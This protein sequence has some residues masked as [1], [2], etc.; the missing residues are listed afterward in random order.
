M[1]NFYQSPPEISTSSQSY[2]LTKKAK[3]GWSLDRRD[4]KTIEAFMPLWEW[5]YQYYF[6]VQTSGWEHVSPNEKVLL[7]G[8]HN[9]GLAAPDM[10]LMMYDWFKRFGTE[11]PIY[12][13]MHPS[14]WQ[15]N[16]QIAELAA[17]VGAIVA[18]PKMGYKAL[19]SGAS[20]LVYPGGAKDVFRPYSLRDRIY[21]GNNQAFIKLALR[22][23]VPIVPVISHGA[24]DTFIVLADIYD[25][26]KQ[27]HDWGMPWFMGIDPET[28]PIYLGLPWGVAFGPLPNIPFPVTI[29][30]RVCP[31]IV[32]ESYGREAA[33]DREYVNACYN[34]V[35]SQMQRELD[36]LVRS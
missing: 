17:K 30:T 5:F 26:I 18:H 11:Q 36:I 8:S 6:R 32:F 9:G 24:H 7:V 3:L 27:L 23:K 21:F 13:L 33:C 28:F 16:S 2:N 34:T 20:V 14:A 15:L 25:F 31:P 35:V 29:R 22:E 10:I 12:G 4:P 19:R 1:S